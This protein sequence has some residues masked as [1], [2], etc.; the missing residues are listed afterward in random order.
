[1]N[2]GYPETEPR[3]DTFGR[4]DFNQAM[5]VV[6]VRSDKTNIQRWQEACMELDSLV[7]RWGFRIVTRTS[8]SMHVGADQ[9]TYQVLGERGQGIGDHF[10]QIKVEVR[11]ITYLYRLPDARIVFGSIQTIDGWS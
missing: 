6:L 4:D 10:D 5:A 11:H 7:R 8:G 1:M 2:D 3:T 9:R